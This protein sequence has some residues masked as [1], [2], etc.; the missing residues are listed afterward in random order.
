M[1][2]FLL[3]FCYGIFL[4][5]N[6]FFFLYRFRFL[7]YDCCCWFRFFIVIFR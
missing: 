4:R 5:F 7:F 6:K 1:F 3:W 2:I